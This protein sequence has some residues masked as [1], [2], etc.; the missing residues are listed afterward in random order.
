M[1][2][3][4]FDS[5]GGDYLPKVVQEK[6]NEIGRWDRQMF[7]E[8]LDKLPYTHEVLTQESFKD[9]TDYLREKGS[10]K[11]YCISNEYGHRMTSSVSIVDIDTSKPW[12]IHIYDGAESIEY[13]NGVTVKNS[14]TN[15]SEW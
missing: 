9:D 11:I 14:E 12:R 8:E 6:V 10:N 15:E 7:A 5:F 1:K 3:A 2:I 13:F 4:I